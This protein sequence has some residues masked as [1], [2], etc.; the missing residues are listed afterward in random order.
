MAIY[1]YSKQKPSIAKKIVSTLSI[2]FILAGVSLII[3][4]VY[5]II[6]F[7][8]YY[9]PKYQTVIS[10]VVETDS[11]PARIGQALGAPFADL[12]QARLWFPQAKPL[13]LMRNLNRYSLTIQR[14]K[15]D[16]AEVMLGG[17]DLSKSLIQFT[18]P[19]PGEIG[20]PVIFGHSTLLLFYN[21]KDYK[22]I[23]SKLP[24]LNIGDLIGVEVDNVSFVFRVYKMY[25]TGPNDLSVLNQDTETRDL[26]LVTCVP[27]GT[28]F[29]RFIVKARLE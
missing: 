26:T 1:S 6:S 8:L 18:G 3:T 7:E 19:I 9:S 23:F 25:I 2:I 11:V 29:K 13:K 16:K 20:N 5:P 4:V 21:T 14:L 24:E 22:A 27:P 17:E 10:P 12:T 15:I 28:Y